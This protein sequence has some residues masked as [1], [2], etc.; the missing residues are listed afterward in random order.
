MTPRRSRKSK[1]RQRSGKRLTVLD[2]AQ[3]EE[4]NA[5]PKV[6]TSCATLRHRTGPRLSGGR[7]KVEPPKQLCAE[8]GLRRR[9]AAHFAARLS[10]VVGRDGLQPVS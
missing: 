8:R 1:R 4:P 6:A 2:H 5:A 10:S 3:P 9:T 7:C